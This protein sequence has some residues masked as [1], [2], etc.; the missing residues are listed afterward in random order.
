LLSSIF[1]V[2]LKS[3]FSGRH[4]SQGGKVGQNLGYWVI[5][6]FGQFLKNC[7]SSPNFWGKFSTLFFSANFD[8]K[9]LGYSLGDFFQKWIW[10]PSTL[11]CTLDA[12]YLFLF[13]FQVFS[14]VFVAIM[15]T[16]Y[17]FQ[18]VACI[19]LLTV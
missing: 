4:P 2:S 18:A 12:V 17:T 13:S 9:G 1:C 5:V 8:E 15:A 7:R 10:S 3:S 16:R 6:Y 19:G 14:T 11:H